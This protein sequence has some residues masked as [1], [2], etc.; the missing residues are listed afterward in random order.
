[1]RERRQSVSRGG[2]EKSQLLEYAQSHALSIA[3]VQAQIDSLAHADEWGGRDSRSAGVR[4]QS[5]GL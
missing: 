4:E 2:L 3:Q 5:R 1:M